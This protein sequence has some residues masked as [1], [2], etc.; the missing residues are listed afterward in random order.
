MDRFMMDLVKQSTPLSNPDVM[1]GLATT[2]LK[3]TEE[4]I[5]AIFISAAKSFPKGLVYIGCETCTPQEEFAETTR[6]KNNKRTIDIARSDLYLMKYFFKYNDVALPPRYLYLPFVGE[7]GTLFLGGS[8]F[9]VS[10]VLTDKVISPGKNNV[11]IRLLRDKV[12]FERLSHSMLIN[13]R[14][15]TTQIIYSAIYR[16][17]VEIKKMV[18]T[19]KAETCLSHYL[20]AKHGFYN[21][22]EMYAGFKPIVG[23]A[24]INT[25][26]Y[27][28]DTWTI[29]SSAQLK[30][31]TFMGEFYKPTDIYVAIPNTHWNAFTKALV[32]EFFYTVDHFPSR[33]NVAHIENKSIWMILLGHI[34]FSGVYGE[35]KL[36]G[37]IQEHFNSLDEYIDNLIAMQ[38]KELGFECKTFYDLLVIVIKNFNDWVITGSE[39]TN[40]L[41][42]KELSIL[43]HM[44]FEIT[45]A[46]FRTGFR[47][48]KIASKKELTEKEI[49]TVMNKQ[50]RSGLIYSITR[51]HVN[52]STVSYSGDNKFFK[53]TSMMVPQISATNKTVRVKSSKSVA[54]DPSKSIHVSIAEVGSHLYIPKSSPRG[55]S[56]ISP[57]VQVAVNGSVIQNENNKLLLDKVA[58]RIKG[59]V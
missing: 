54:D 6:A 15:E 45:S 50:L 8:R 59:I 44:L 13:G 21:T 9:V 37:N 35:G 33:I 39:Q 51:S 4:Y 16:K 31:K 49:T 3:Y 57:F 27:P 32:S 17:S 48:N 12:T 11:F 7:A 36:F 19:T 47:L 38:L 23:N 14:R 29:C 1:N 58:N 24:E 10:P 22:F 43:Y 42:G 26:T 2:H 46:I 30:P 18:Q 34:I 53:I 40:S 25:H 56:R 28:A 55:D 5:N 52:M 20:F 41:Y